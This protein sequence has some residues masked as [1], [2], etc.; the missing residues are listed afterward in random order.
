[1]S[2][3]PGT[4]AATTRGLAM[5]SRLSDYGGRLLTIDGQRV[6]Q[7]VDPNDNAHRRHQYRRADIIPAAQ[8]HEIAALPDVISVSQDRIE[9]W[10]ADDVEASINEI[11]A[12]IPDSWSGYVGDYHVSAGPRASDGRLTLSLDLS[13]RGQ[14]IERRT[15]AADGQPF[16]DSGSPWERMTADELLAMWR[17]R[18]DYHPVLDA[19]DYDPMRGGR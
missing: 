11:C 16:R 18:G 7:L 10:E 12:C 1:M 2:A 4:R 17:V 8:L 9:M 13:S 14:V 6:V 3:A 5:T 15:L 19:L